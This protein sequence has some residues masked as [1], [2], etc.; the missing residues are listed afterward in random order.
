MDRGDHGLKKKYPLTYPKEGLSGPYLMEEIYRATKGDA[1]I[2]TE[3]GQ[4]QMW[5]HSITN[6]KTRVPFY[7][8][9]T[10][11]DGLWTWSCDRCTDRQSG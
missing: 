5:Q 1:V 2:V 7:H 11:N 9:W 6:T 3:V 4:H 10:R 8:R